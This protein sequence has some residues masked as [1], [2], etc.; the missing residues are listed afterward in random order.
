MNLIDFDK[1]RLLKPELVADLPTGAKRWMQ[2]PR[3]YV[4]TL[5]SG[6]TTF[7]DGVPTGALPGGLVR[8]PLRHTLRDR[9]AE[10]HADT[11]ATDIVDV[12]SIPEP[13]STNDVLVRD[14]DLVGG[15]SAMARAARK[16]LKNIRAAAK[17]SSTGEMLSGRVL[18][19]VGLDSQGRPL[20]K[21]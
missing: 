4:R 11:Q 18:N 1:L 21:L 12:Q 17:V 5:V 2:R 6:V 8:N 13:H 10:V 15:P 14:E 20:A 19:K 9:V 7:L 16:N 3:G